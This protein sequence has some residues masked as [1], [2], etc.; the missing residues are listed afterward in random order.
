MC[1]VYARVVVLYGT[2]AVEMEGHDQFVWDGD[3]V[4]EVIELDDGLE[5]SEGD[6]IFKQIRQ[7]DR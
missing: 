3:D 7:M 2:C 1:V 4:E 6:A 5:Q